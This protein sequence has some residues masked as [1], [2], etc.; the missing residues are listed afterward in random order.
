MRKPNLNTIIENNLDKTKFQSKAQPSLP[1]D[2][3]LSAYKNGGT[4]ISDRAK[5][6]QFGQYAEGGSSWMLTNPNRMSTFFPRMNNGGGLQQYQVAGT[7]TSTDSLRHQASKM[8]DYEARKGSPTGQ[9]L[10]DW[11]YHNSQLPYNKVPSNWYAPQTKEAAVDMYMNEIGKNPILGYFNSA[12]EKGEA[13]DFLY[14]TGRDPRVYMLDQ[15]LRSVGQAGLPNRGSYN[16]DTK[17]PQWTPALQG[18]LDQAWNQYAPAINKLPVNQRRVLLNKGRDFYYQN[19]NQVNGKPNPSYEATWKPRIWESV[20]TYR[21]GGGLLSR[22]VTC[23]SCGHSWKGV[24]GGLDPLT[25][26]ECGGMIK[27]QQGGLTKYQITGQVTKTKKEPYRSNM[28]NYENALMTNVHP[29]LQSQME[30]AKNRNIKKGIHNGPLDAIRHAGSAAGASSEVFPFWV[31]PSLKVIGANVLGAAHEF[32]T[33][34]KIDWKETGSDL[35]N[36]FIG[37]IIGA[38]PISNYKKQQMVID[39]QNNGVLSNINSWRNGGDISIPNLQ[40]GNWLNRYDVGGFTVT[41]ETTKPK[42]Q[43]GCKGKSCTQTGDGIKKVGVRD[44]PEAQGN[45]ENYVALSN[46]PT[47]WEELLTYNETNPKDKAFKNQLKTLQTQFP[48]LTQQQMLAA[49]ADSARIRQRMGNLPRYDQPSE[50]TYDRAYHMFYRPLM[51]QQTPVTIP[52]ILQYQSQQPGGL[53]GFESTVRGNYGRPKAQNGQQVGNPDKPYSKNNPQG[54]VSMKNNQDWFNSH[55]NWTNTGNPEWDAKV[56]Q[57]VMTGRFGVDPNSGALI[58][59]PKNEWTNVSDEYKGLATDKRQLTSAQKQ[60]SWE[61]QVKPYI[62]QSTKDLIT[63]PVMMAPGAILTGGIAAGIPAI[64]R[65]AAAIAPA[66]ETSIAGVPGLT[67]GNLLNSYFAY[68]GAKNIPNVH[69][70]W[71]QV[72]SNPTWSNVGNAAGETAVSGIN[73]LPFG[74]SAYKGIP[75]VMQDI[76]QAGNWLT[77]QTPLKDTYKINPWAFK[78]NPQAFYRQIGKT[79]LADAAESGVIKSADISTFPRPHF[80]EGKDF[81][82]LYSTGEGATGSRPSVIFETSGVNQAGEPFVFPANSTSG[83]TPWIAGE[84][85]V[86]LSQG[87]VLQKNWLRGYK[88]IEI[89]TPKSL[90]SSVEAPTNLSTINLMREGNKAKSKMYKASEVVQDSNFDIKKIFRGDKETPKLIKIKGKSGDWTINKANDGTY[91]FNASMSNPLES[92][93][94]ML[95]INEL[96]PP[97]PTILEP[98]SLSLDSYKNVLKL[99]KRPNWKMQ[100]ENYIPLNHS[101]IHD[102]TIFNKFGFTPEGY[103]VPFE[104]LD[105]ANVALKEINSMLKKQG[106]EQQADVFSNGVGLYGIKIPNFRLTRNYGYGGSID[107][108]DKYQVAG[109]VVNN[110]GLAN[111]RDLARQNMGSNESTSSGFTMYKQP[112]GMPI[113]REAKEKAYRT[114]R[115]SEETDLKNYTRWLTNTT[116]TQFDEPRSEEAWRMYLGVPGPNQYFSSSNTRPSYGDKSYKNYY[117]ADNQLEQDIFNT[118][119]D[120]IKPG[121]SRIVDESDV[122]SNWGPDDNVTNDGYLIIQPGDEN[123]IFGRP[124]KSRARALGHFTINRGADD[125]GDYISY[126]DIY[127]FPDWIQSRTKGIPFDIYNRIYYPKV[128]NKKQKKKEGGM[129]TDPRGQWAHPGKNTRIPGNNITMQG[130]PYPVLAKANNS[131]ST[132][133]MYP[134]QDYNFPEADY[135][136]EYPLPMAQDGLISFLP[137]Q[138]P[139]MTYRDRFNTPLNKRQTKRFNEWAAEESERQG[140]DIMMDKGAY[141]VQGFWKSGDY[142]RMVKGHGTDT[143]KKPNHPTF[144]NQSKYHGIDGFYGGN[145]TPEDGYQPSKQTADM[146]GPS[147]YNWLFGREPERPEHLDAS[148]YTSGANAPSPLYYKNGGWLKKYQDG[149]QVTYTVKKGDTLSQIGKQFGMTPQQIA[150]ANNISNIDF[151]RTNQKLNIPGATIPQQPAVGPTD[152]PIAPVQFQNTLPS[153]VQTQPTL[154]GNYT[155]SP[156]TSINIKNNPEIYSELDPEISSIISNYTTPST[157]DSAEDTKKRETARRIVEIARKHIAMGKEGYFEVPADIAAASRKEGKEPAGCVGG[158]CKIAQEAGAMPKIF[159]SNTAFTKAAPELGFPNKGYGLR[160]IQNL[161]A[162]DFMVHQTELGGYDDKGNPKYIPRHTQIFLGINPET[163]Q[164]EFFDNFHKRLMSYSEDDIRDKLKQTKNSYDYGSVIYKN[165]PFHPTA[166]SY[167]DETVQQAADKEL[168]VK[169]QMKNPSKYKYSIRSDAKDY[170]DS[171]KGIMNTFVNYANDD[172]NITDLVSKLKVGKDEIHDSLLNVFGELGQ[173]NNWSNSGKG[174]KSKAENVAEKV[175]TFFGGAKKY[176]VGPGQNKFSTIPKDLREQF[177]IKSPK[178]LYDINKVIPLMVAE[179]I[180]NKQVLRRW[181]QQNVL[182]HKLIGHTDKENPLRADDLKGGVGRWSPYLRNEFG[183]ISSGKRII[184]NNDLIP[185]NGE[186]VTWD[187]FYKPGAGKLVSNYDMNAGMF[188]NPRTLAEGSYPDKVFHKTDDNL[189]RTLIT[190][191]TE[192]SPDTLPTKYVFSKAKKKKEFGGQNN[193]LNNYR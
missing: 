112:E 59:L 18:S 155:A 127:D 167:T 82:K 118:F 30:L 43:Y 96:L 63:N 86:P 3:W 111:P 161:E 115:P 106:I 191:N 27:M 15:Y 78:V 143:W 70:A 108:L 20:N 169:E 55:A 159:W 178:D 131:M 172:K 51:N 164:Y 56:R 153:F 176:S 140:R 152:V 113:N 65:T 110:F 187:N 114:I 171:T 135:V 147:Y 183:L 44:M 58:K 41:D 158:A 177:D 9:G 145:W 182:S 162:G 137:Q 157:L 57:Q 97:K 100:F 74:M 60:Q 61:R 174:L 48:G 79:G 46:A 129:I 32:T 25:C 128:D 8:M 151:I 126:Q 34:G 94:A 36:N 14:N 99:G 189:Q 21:N 45:G 122:T 22:T 136:D 133:K 168:F 64:S 69:N 156:D 6:T 33:P 24:T 88:P 26:H 92:G 150:D 12:M 17:T 85:E 40:E 87:K 142:N 62:Q 13:G 5:A 160:G 89:P 67:A 193:W 49:G 52:Q 53:Q 66:L 120:D 109:Q 165:N 117:K 68:E 170:N 91:Y 101:A 72:G 90:S 81:T 50:Q 121:E 192:T 7:V 73:M 38:L 28:H 190:P 102:K 185:W 11:G 130:V 139:E 10:S 95:K 84:A 104:S 166:N 107:W 71:R 105:D 148:R 179:D 175:L 181:G 75:S 123:K 103:T 184:N 42:K 125:K 134:G 119:K 1:E 37:S 180:R 31:P 124:A 138:D 186:D 154:Q 93:K 77:T 2:G 4:Y 16:V 173:E 149:N 80:V 163:K 83:Y 188:M 19:I 116:R 146:Y 23:S 144:S 35:Y 132:I 54:Y 39:A 29:Y 141:D 98:N 47:T 76:N